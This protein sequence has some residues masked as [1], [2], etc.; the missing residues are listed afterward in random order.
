MRSTFWTCGLKLRSTTTTA[1]TT[2]ITTQSQ[3]F[4]GLAGKKRVRRKLVLIIK[5]LSQLGSVMYENINNK[6][7]NNNSSINYNSVTHENINNESKNPIMLLWEK[8]KTTLFLI[9]NH[10]LYVKVFSHPLLLFR[11]HLLSSDKTLL[12]IQTR[13][14]RGKWI[15]IYF[16]CLFLFSLRTEQSLEIKFTSFSWWLP[17]YILIVFALYLK[18]SYAP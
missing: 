15:S 8:K 2:T 14:L 18:Q 9:E 10:L 13:E 4:C 3:C 16:F 6:S 11:A 12:Y 7:N 5:P 1:T 17:F